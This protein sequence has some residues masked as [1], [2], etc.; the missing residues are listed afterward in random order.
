MHT[1]HQTHTHGTKLNVPKT[2]IILIV[3]HHKTSGLQLTRGPAQTCHFN[4]TVV[5]RIVSIVQNEQEFQGET[6]LVKIADRQTWSSSHR[7][8]DIRPS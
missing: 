3:R 1:T 5:I 4:L 6:F 7:A 8:V 2:G